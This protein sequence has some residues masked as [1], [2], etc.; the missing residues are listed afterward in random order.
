MDFTSAQHTGIIFSNSDPESKSTLRKTVSKL[1]RD[2]T[3]ALIESWRFDTHM[4]FRKS[5]SQISS[6]VDGLTSIIENWKNDPEKQENKIEIRFQSH[7]SKVEDGFR[8]LLESDS[9][10]QHLLAE[11]FADSSRNRLSL[12]LSNSSGTSHDSTLMGAPKMVRPT[13]S[14]QP[15]QL[16]CSCCCHISVQYQPLNL[17]NRV[18]GRLLIEYSTSLWFSE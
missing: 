2:S 5:V 7:S 8:A 9:R 1:V 6:A 12:E 16:K 11:A 10:T 4:S 13:E 17:C 3:V 18:M 14:D 15:C